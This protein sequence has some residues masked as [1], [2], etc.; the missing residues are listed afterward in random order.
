MECGEKTVRL[1]K[2]CGFDL[3]L[4]STLEA[5]KEGVS[6]VTENLDAIL[7]VIADDPV[8]DLQS[9]IALEYFA[10]K[11]EFPMLLTLELSMLCRLTEFPQLGGGKELVG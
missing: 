4:L 8:L 10:G 11:I 5:T 7:L 9:S 3:E 6:D 1:G 2:S